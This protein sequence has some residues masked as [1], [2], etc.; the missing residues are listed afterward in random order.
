MEKEL[1]TT[2]LQIQG[3]L[4]I[5]HWQTDSYAEHI[6]FGETYNKIVELFD[7]LVEVYSGKYKKLFLGELTKIDFADL[8]MININ[9]FIKSAVDFLSDLFNSDQDCE[10]KNIKDEIVALLHKLNYLLTLK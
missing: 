5:F 6:A 10:L 7:D 3:Q 4:R 2:I 8:T 9:V 1:L